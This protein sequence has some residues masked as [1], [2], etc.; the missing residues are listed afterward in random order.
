MY[1]ND[2]AEQM[3]EYK[4]VTYSDH[5]P[6]KF[7]R[8]FDDYDKALEYYKNRIGDSMDANYVA[9][10]ALIR[11]E[12]GVPIMRESWRVFQGYL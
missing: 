1:L 11:V 6:D 5:F 10:V 12:T 9:G 2:V 3:R 4:V 7:V 8:Y